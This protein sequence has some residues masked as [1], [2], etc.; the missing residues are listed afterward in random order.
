MLYPDG[1]EFVLNLRVS[2]E[3]GFSVSTYTRA[4]GGTGEASGETGER[5]GDSETESE[6]ESERE[7]LTGQL[8]R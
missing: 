3:G 8:L 4:S 7:T 1:N 6:S 2:E 5:E